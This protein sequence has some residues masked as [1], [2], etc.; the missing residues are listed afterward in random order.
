MLRALFQNPAELS[1]TKLDILFTRLRR[2]DDELQ[3]L[4]ELMPANLYNLNS[5]HAVLG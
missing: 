2:G 1:P 3:L 5:L 4:A